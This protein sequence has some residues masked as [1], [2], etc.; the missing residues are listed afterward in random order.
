VLLGRS[1][2]DASCT[3]PD[4]RFDLGQTRHRRVAW[5]CH[6]E[7]TMCRAVLDPT[8]RCHWPGRL[9]RRRCQRLIFVPTGGVDERTLA[10]YLAHPAVLAVGGSW[11]VPRE[12]VR[13]CAFEQIR[14][15]VAA[16]TRLASVC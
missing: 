6:C 14:S 9:L 3:T 8:T 5:R 1:A 11:M 10:T 13:A 12:L 16:A 4:D 2:L 15:T 7:R